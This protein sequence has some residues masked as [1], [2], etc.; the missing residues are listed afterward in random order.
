MLIHGPCR[1]AATAKKATATAKKAV[2]G[3]KDVAQELNVPSVLSKHR[4]GAGQLPEASP[5]KAG[6]GQ[7]LVAPLA[8]LLVRRSTTAEVRRSS[9]R[10]SSSNS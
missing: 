2:S 7:L 6:P 4:A 9:S 10:R 3:I 1:T 8:D 5:S